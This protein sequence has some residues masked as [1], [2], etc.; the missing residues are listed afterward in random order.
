MKSIFIAEGNQSVERLF[1][2]VFARHNWVVTSTGD[3]N[4]AVEALRGAEHYD[5]VLVSYE[6]QG[7]NGVELTKLVRAFA[8]RTHTPVV[9]VTGSGGIEVEALNAGV[10][11]ILYKPID[12]YSLIAAASKY[13][14]ETGPQEE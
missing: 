12:I 2:T 8:H 9:M 14:F 10:S 4:R 5:V 11:E 3:C 7:M 13:I 1:A 6:M